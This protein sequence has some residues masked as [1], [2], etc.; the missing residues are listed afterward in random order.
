MSQTIKDN[1][2]YKDFIFDTAVIGAGPAGLSAAVRARFI[3][4]HGAYPMSAVVFDSSETAGGL[5]NFGGTKLTG[6]AFTLERGELISKL[7]KDIELFDIPIIGQKVI[8]V[9]KSTRGGEFLIKTESGNEA[10]TGAK[11]II[12]S[13]RAKS[14]I[15]ASGMRPLSNELQYFNKGVEITYM[16][17]DFINK[18]ISG[19]INDA[20]Q[21]DKKLIIYGNKYSLNLIN[22]V[23]SAINGLKVDFNKMS[24]LFLINAD[25]KDIQKIKTGKIFKKYP[26]L[27]SFGK[28]IK[29]LG[30]ARLESIAVESAGKHRQEAVDR[31]LLDYNS[32]ELAPDF[33][34]KIP[35]TASIFTTAG[36]IKTDANAKTRIKG[37]YAA[38]DI[39]GPYYSVSRAMAGGI[40][41]AFSAYEFVMRE[42]KH[43]KNFSMF[44][45]KAS[46][47]TPGIDY[48]EISI[49]LN[50]DKIAV[51]SQSRKIKKI[52]APK[53]KNT[54]AADFNKLLDY[55][56]IY[57]VLDINDFN[58]IS[59]LL[60]IQ[61]IE[62]SRLVEFMI[63]EK[64]AGIY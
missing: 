16:G 39:C 25:D 7:L 27:F 31:V 20:A 49:D 2:N 10:K 42:K 36:F 9:K 35:K 40:T 14:V 15:I 1:L 28:I 8:E 44:A 64:L 22:F 47:F 41:A 43:I 51:L 11:N 58:K 24:P 56:S 21:N 4:S 54:P 48:R 57:R 55:F 29:F 59:K 26:F 37:L 17:Y 52:L 18:M 23:I 5:A 3:K 33:D 46:N 63:E 12:N 6:P 60:N 13:Y 50:V 34:I 61:L 19:F 45:Y 30:T 38:G 53:L 32:F 62:L